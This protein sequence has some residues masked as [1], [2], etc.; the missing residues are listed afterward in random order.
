MKTF[1]PALMRICLCTIAAVLLAMK[2]YSQE[3]GS[4]A[5]NLRMAQTLF[6]K[7]QVEQVPSLI[8]ACL[9]SGFNR[10]ESLEAYKLLIQSYLFEEK[11]EL[12]DS[13]MLAFLKK[14][15]EYQI[16]PTDHSSF[17][18]L[19]NNFVSK[20]IIQVS[21]HLGTSLPFVTVSESRSLSGIPSEKKYSTDALNLFASV[22]VKYK[23]NEKIELNA[24]AGYSRIA[25][26]NKEDF[27]VFD[28]ISYREYQKRIEIPIS[29]SYNLSSIGI[30]TPYARL[31]LGPSFIFSSIAQSVVEP[32]DENNPYDH[33]GKDI[34]MR[35]SRISLEL[36]TQAGAGIKLK[37]REGFIFG[38]LRTNIGLFNQSKGGGFSDGDDLSWFYYH[39]DDKFRV[40][41]LNFNLGYTRIF[42]KP[43]RK[44]D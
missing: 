41:S 3:A 16:S 44:K 28:E 31:G 39:A 12:A 7:G 9:K 14:N 37:T 11:L 15:P 19:F 6:E 23:I 29:I 13:T 35:S 22:E 30:F 40:N 10:E 2:G 24:E 26:S 36:I 18:N 25:F 43:S 8:S 42:Y 34:N 5:E 20:V 33:S 17:V 32:T 4:C 21:F 1:Y 27:M 38:E